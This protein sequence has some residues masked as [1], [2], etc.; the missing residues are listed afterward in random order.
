MSRP[1]VLIVQGSKF[2]FSKSR[3]LA[4]F[5]CK[6]VAKKKLVPSVRALLSFICSHDHGADY[7]FV[8]SGLRCQHSQ[9]LGNFERWVN[10]SF[11]VFL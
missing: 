1:V 7:N 10:D 4:T 9:T 6:M 3:L 5:N 2:N 8:D 11:L